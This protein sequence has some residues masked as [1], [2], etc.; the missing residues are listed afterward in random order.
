MKWKMPNRL[1]KN[2]CTLLA[3]K[4]RKWVST[5]ALRSGLQK[6]ATMSGKWIAATSETRQQQFLKEH[7]EQQWDE[8]YGDRINK[9]VVIGRNMDKEGII[10]ELD[11]CLAG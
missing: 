6:T 2:M 3:T 7:P 8:V 5:R 11:H 1:K 10:K 9:L 4:K